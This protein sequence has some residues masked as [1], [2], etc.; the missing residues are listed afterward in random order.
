MKKLVLLFALLTLPLPSFAYFSQVNTGHVIKT[1]AYRLSLSP[2]FITSSDLGTGAN[3]TGRFD[4]GL[5]DASDMRVQVGFGRVDFHVGGLYKWVP[6]PD[7]PDQ[8]AIGLLAGAY[9]ARQS[10]VGTF[11]V[12]AFPF[13]SKQFDTVAGMF[14]PYVSLPLGLSATSSVTEMPVQLILG[15]EWMPPGLE[16][17]SF[18]VESGFNVNKAFSYLSL[19]LSLYWDD[20]TGIE[21]K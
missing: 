15:T 18:W 3:F 12:R 1:G 13:I 8:P 20:Q 17:I 5:D 4:T 21:F 16:K 6:I 11:S 10:S 9:F 14:D 7:T 19:M 2:Q